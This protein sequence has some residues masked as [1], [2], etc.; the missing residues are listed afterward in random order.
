[1][2]TDGIIAVVTLIIIAI[3]VGLI[4][5]Y[6]ATSVPLAQIA[7]NTITTTESDLTLANPNVYP[8]YP[9]LQG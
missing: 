4:L 2:K 3:V 5:R 7:A 9:P 6:G 1:M 8:Y